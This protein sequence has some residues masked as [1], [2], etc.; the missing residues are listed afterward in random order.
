MGL[1]GLLQGQ[2]YL[3]TEQ[4]ALALLRHKE[5]IAY[6]STQKTELLAVTAAR[7]SDRSASNDVYTFIVFGKICLLFARSIPDEII[8]LFN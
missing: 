7:A 4:Q 5:Q 2:I 8:E 1:H 3:Y 6:Y